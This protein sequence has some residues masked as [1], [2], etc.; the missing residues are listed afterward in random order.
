DQAIVD[1]VRER[2]SEHGDLIARETSRISSAMEGYVQHGVEAIGQPAGA[3]EG[4]VGT[5]A[6]R[7]TELEE[8][9]TAAFDV[10]VRAVAQ[11]LELVSERLSS[12]TM[13]LNEAISSFGERSEERMR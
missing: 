2:I 10:Q 4:H 7:D 8:R 12:E 13:S 11:Q 6:A 3:G 5:L 1:S 9:V